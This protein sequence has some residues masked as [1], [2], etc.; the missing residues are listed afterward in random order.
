MSAQTLQQLLGWSTLINMG[1]LLLWFITFR[2]ARDWI[3]RMHSRW[4]RLSPE[5]FDAIHY[6]GMALFK[7]TI[8]VFNLVPWLALKI[9]I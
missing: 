4:F 3:Y 6:G 9:V 1:L 7:M 2:A 5:R 8:M